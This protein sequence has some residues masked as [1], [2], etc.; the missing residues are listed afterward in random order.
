MLLLREV[1]ACKRLV[2]ASGLYLSPKSTRHRSVMTTRPSC[3]LLYAALAFMVLAN[4]GHAHAHLCLDGQEPP[5]VVYFENFGGNPFQHAD[6]VHVD[7][8][9]ELTSQ[10]LSNTKAQ[11]GVMVFL[12]AC[13]LLFSV[14]EASGQAFS[15]SLETI[16]YLP[17]L[18]LN[19][20]SRAPPFL[21]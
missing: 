20:P 4:L 8:E 1:R 5:A 10:M 9:S 19:P 16:D 15:A 6:D 14:P 3:H 12:L 13:S 17:P 21:V 18:R 7:V 2:S 11:Q